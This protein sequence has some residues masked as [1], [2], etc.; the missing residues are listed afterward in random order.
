M[1]AMED[2]ILFV[3]AMLLNACP[4]VNYKSMACAQCLKRKCYCRILRAAASG[5]MY[6][7]L[8]WLKRGIY[9]LNK[10]H[11]WSL[12]VRRAIVVV[13]LLLG[14]LNQCLWCPSNLEEGSNNWYG[15]G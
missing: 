7:F 4:V 10:E 15:Q 5:L 2:A 13:L 14:N 3:V 1:V 6:G 12:L 9:L 8:A 11:W